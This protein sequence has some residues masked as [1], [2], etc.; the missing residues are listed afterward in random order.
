[1]ADSKPLVVLRVR[2]NGADEDRAA[3]VVDTRDEAIRIPFDVEDGQLTDGLSRRPGRL[4]LNEVLPCG[5][6]GDAVPG[7]KRGFR[8][9]MACRKIAQRPPADDMHPCKDV[10][11]LRTKC[12]EGLNEQM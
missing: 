8:V 4:N 3:A 10:L 12:Q 2:E 1:M 11:I 7:I 6:L 5:G 9:R